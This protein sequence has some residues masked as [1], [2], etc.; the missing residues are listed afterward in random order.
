MNT[1][2]QNK[3]TQA[4]TVLNQGGIIIFPTDTAFGI[5][6]RLDNID[7]ITRLY[8]IKNRPFSKAVP[9]LC[10]SIQMV[11]RYLSSP[12]PNIVRQI[13]SEYWPGGLTI[14]YRANN[15]MSPLLVR[16]GGNNLGVRIP[17]HDIP[18]Q[19]IKE[20]KVPLLGPSANFT[21]FPT[22]F[23]LKELDDKLVRKVDLV[24]NGVC[25]LKK[26]STVVD[27]S[28]TSYK[29]VRQGAVIINKEFLK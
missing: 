16:G 20:I 15:I 21:N 6:C 7:S 28:K 3:I 24:I 4:I 8:K 25:S 5:G 13:M 23:T 22:P 9:I 27:F 17:N 14:V 10:D 2:L 19:I 11:K 1:P 18:A 26:P 12:L 29:I